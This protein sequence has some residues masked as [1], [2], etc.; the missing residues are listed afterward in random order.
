MTNIIKLNNLSQKKN[1]KKYEKYITVSYEKIFMKK[2]GFID[3]SLL[4]AS[5][6]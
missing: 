1:V 5:T 3:R 6:K 2:K 4:D